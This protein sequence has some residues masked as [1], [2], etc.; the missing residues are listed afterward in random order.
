[1]VTVDKV[2]FQD[3]PLKL[4]PLQVCARVIKNKFGSSSLKI[5]AGNEGFKYQLCVA[6]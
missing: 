3:L 1:M 5:F 2:C 4:E 6:L